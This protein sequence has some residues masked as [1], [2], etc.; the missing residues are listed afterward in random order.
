MRLACSF[1]EAMLKELIVETIE[2]RHKICLTKNDIKFSRDIGP[3][4]KDEVTTV[5]DL[6]MHE[7][8]IKAGEYISLTEEK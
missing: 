6:S 2:K 4:G 3:E 5:V 8:R 1:N 7:E